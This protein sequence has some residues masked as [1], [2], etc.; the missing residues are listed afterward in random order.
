MVTLCFV[1]C[2]LL[3]PGFGSAL[4]MSSSAAPAAPSAVELQEHKDWLKK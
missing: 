3:L 2:H 4:R 1:P